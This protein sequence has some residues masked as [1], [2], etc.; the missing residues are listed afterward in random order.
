MKHRRGFTLIEIL[1]V[2]AIIALLVAITMPSLAGARRASK[3][4]RCQA[5]L[6]SIGLAMKAYLHGN[7]DTFPHVEVLPESPDV[8]ETLPLPI[9]LKNELGS[10]GSKGVVKDPS[11]TG[12][13]RGVI[14]NEVFLC[15]A[16]R[17]TE[18]PTLG[19]N[20]YYDAIHTSYDWN[21]L[22]NGERINF[23]TVVIQFENPP[24]PPKRFPQPISSVVVLY[25]L[26]EWHQE[27][28][29]KKGAYNILYADMH[30]EASPPG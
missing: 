2:V 28:P 15:P 7:R 9:V 30:I 26:E 17:I 13:T 24:L 22:L 14:K 8:P 27:N 3:A 23:K 29:D 16:D 18:D 25:D 20:R 1:V 12:Y 10:G 19:A 21:H 5:N 6:H 11:G 4:A